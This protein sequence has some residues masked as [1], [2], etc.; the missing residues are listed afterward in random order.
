VGGG[1]KKTKKVVQ[2]ALK[3]VQKGYRGQTKREQKKRVRRLKS[4]EA[5]NKNTQEREGEKGKL[6]SDTDTEEEKG[7]EG[8]GGRVQKVK[9]EQAP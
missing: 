9:T 6:R 1:I 7:P 2:H 8:N 5:K 3:R 4:G